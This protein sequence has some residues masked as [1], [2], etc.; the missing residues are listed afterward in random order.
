MRLDR[1]FRSLIAA[2][3]IGVIAC[4]DARAAHLT[5]D[6]YGDLRFIIPSSQDSWMF[7]GLGKFRFG[8]SSG[9]PNIRVGEIVAEATLQATP[10]LM[11]FV[12]LRYDRDQR[13][14][15]DATELY[16]RY[17]P[18]STTRFRWSVK[19]GMFFPPISLENDEVGWTS[20]WTITPSVINSWVGEEL[21]TM[22]G[23][24]R[25]EYRTGRGAI[26]AV[27][28]LYGFNDPAGI[29][30]AFRGWAFDD[31]PTSYADRLRLPDA[32]A[33][34]F[35]VPTPF[36]TL[37]F[38][39][40]DDRVGWYAGLRADDDVFGRIEFLRYDNRAEPDAFRRQFAWKTKF[41]SAGIERRFGILTLMAQGM[42]GRTVV[43]PAD[44][45]YNNWN[46]DAAYVLAGVNLGKWR[47]AV[48]GDIFG[49]DRKN[50]TPPSTLSQENGHGVTGSVSFY[51]R[52]WVRLSAEII[53]AENDNT[54]RARSGLT[55][56]VN[57]TQVQF[58]TR[59]YF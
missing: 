38:K 36:R 49:T 52:N 53:R 45:V 9:D 8:K 30:L 48:R 29:L 51:P 31:R 10:S 25:L 28:A 35:H 12:S 2:A 47:L 43:E 1:S 6:G 27:G 26:E 17:R 59:V 14:A 13:R 56:R 37:E 40:I 3:A 54:L 24:G 41:W 50:S 18:V 58:L 33:A 42:T 4:H 5:V 57:E 21:R 19:V 55:P 16:V 22:G 7:G 34:V 46:F 32:I 20:G 39:E 23:E 44:E 15:I 11:G